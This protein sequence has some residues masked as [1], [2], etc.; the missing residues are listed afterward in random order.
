MTFK[1]K[2]L[3]YSKNLGSGVVAHVG[4]DSIEVEHFHGS[5]SVEYDSEGR[6]FENMADS[7]R[8]V[9]LLAVS[10]NTLKVENWTYWLEKGLLNRYRSNFH[11]ETFDKRAAESA[12]VSMVFATRYDLANL[13]QSF[14][15]YGKLPKI[16]PP[17]T[18]EIPVEDGWIGLQRYF[19]NKVALELNVKTDFGG[20]S[21]SA[22]FA[23]E[24]LIKFL[25]TNEL[26]L[27]GL[28]IKD[29]PEAEY[30]VEMSGV[31]LIID[32]HQ[33]IEILDFLY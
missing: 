15:K 30:Q 4:E 22:A 27:E 17:K 28:T 24:E 12:R 14:A 16:A 33:L 3:V 18:L 26:R 2:D 31:T 23:R 21:T 11:W 8:D 13:Y 6:Y 20:S 10:K 9:N 5:I 1:E 7:Y 19:G 32:E 25:E 29:L